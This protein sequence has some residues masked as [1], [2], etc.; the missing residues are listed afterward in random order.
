MEFFYIS[1][2]LLGIARVSA[3][4]DHVKWLVCSQVGHC[5]SI[6]YLTHS[7]FFFLITMIGP[8]RNGS[9]RPQVRGT[10]SYQ[11]ATLT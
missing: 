6:S 9:L 1:F 7:M 8:T 5:H 2:I 4:D 11:C 3:G 10:L